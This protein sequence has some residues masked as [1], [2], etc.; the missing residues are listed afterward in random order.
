[1]SGRRPTN[2]DVKTRQGY[3]TCA[4][5]RDDVASASEPTRGGEQAADHHEPT[6]TDD[7]S[8]HRPGGTDTHKH[9]PDSHDHQNADEEGRLV[10]G[11]EQIDRSRLDSGWHAVDHPVADGNH[12]GSGAAEDPSEQLTDPE[13]QRCRKQTGETA[14]WFFGVHIT[15]FR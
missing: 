4:D 6:H 3:E 15:Q 10:V 14:T 12:R 5:D 2:Q 9:G 7:R 8:P 1:M 13:A 11:S